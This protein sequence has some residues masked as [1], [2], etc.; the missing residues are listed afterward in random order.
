MSQL[1]MQI[2]EQQSICRCME[3]SA[4]N[5]CLWGEYGDYTQ[6][7][8]EVYMDSQFVLKHEEKHDERSATGI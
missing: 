1:R 4:P 7:I 3:S 6:I 5:S 2:D 8:Y